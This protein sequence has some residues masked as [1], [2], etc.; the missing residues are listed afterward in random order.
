MTAIQS[1][2]GIGSL[3]VG[4]HKITKS[5]ANGVV[6][7]IFKKLQ[8]HSEKSS[9]DLDR[10][11]DEQDEQF[12]SSGW[13]AEASS[14]GITYES[15]GAGRSL[16]DVSSPGITPG[17]VV[18]GTGVSVAGGRHHHSH[19][20][21]I[22]GNSVATSN[23]GSGA[24][25]VGNTFIHPSKQVPRTSTP[26]VYAN[27]LASLTAESRDYSP[28]INEDEDDDDNNTSADHLE[29]HRDSL[30]I[31]RPQNHHYYQ[32]P[33][34][35]YS[36]SQPSLGLTRPSPKHRST[37]SSFG[38]GACQLPTLKINTSRSI[39]TSTIAATSTTSTTPAQYPRLS[40]DASRSDRHADR[41]V[42]SSSP[43][44]APS[45]QKIKS[46]IR[47]PTSPVAP[48]SP[49]RSSFENGF[50]LRAK[51]DL[52]T[53]TRAEHLREARRKFEMKEKAKDEKYA[54]EEIRRR[55]RAD[56]KR[57]QE[58]ERQAAAALREQNAV[59]ARQEAAELEEAMLHN[60]HRR[61]ISATSSG[62]PSLSNR[63]SVTIT[64]PSL[65]R[66]NTPTPLEEPEKFASSNY[67]NLD[68][69]HPPAFGNEAGRARGAG[70][71]GAKRSTSAKKKTHSAWHMF[72]LW[73]R[74]KLLRVGRK[75]KRH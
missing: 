27:S 59:Q 12:T 57:A 17:Y 34:N 6:K 37:S 70:F 73:L 35:Y 10:G 66:K 4:H 39:S 3:G 48:M 49:I 50:R 16:I 26:P 54:R 64:R 20:R 52:D 61:K 68:A 5:R 58:A 32:P 53:V 15:A 19:S 11:W 14:T 45:S 23:S 56:K 42:E 63:P 8:A 21:S 74:T 65:S 43:S 25:R 75:K 69:S 30:N 67:D 7:P 2:P 40:R 28:I 51:S 1:L 13:G 31:N 46:P 22:S 24:P 71:Q 44:N 36:H 72:L 29:E 41:A 33:T 62:R 60:K 9:L 18:G 38:E 55:E 47:S